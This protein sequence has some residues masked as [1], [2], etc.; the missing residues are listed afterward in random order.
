MD[1]KTQKIGRFRR[2]MLGIMGQPLSKML[3]ARTLRKKIDRSPA[4]FPADLS[5]SSDILFILPQDRVEMVFLLESLFAILGRY[6]NSNVTFLCPATHAPY[7]SGRK[8]VQVI[9]Y[10]PAE[11]QIYGAEFNRLAGELSNRAFDICVLFEKEY[12]LAHLYFVGLSRAHLRIGWDSGN[13]YP[14]LNVRLV[15]TVRKGVTVWERNLEIAKILDANADTT[16]RWGV[17]QTTADEVMQLL[18]EYKLKKDLPLICIDLASLER[19]CGGAWC[20]ELLNAL[21]GSGMRQFYIFG[22]PEEEHQSFKE[23]PF[24]VLPSMSIP[25]TAALIASTEVV[26]TGP[27][28]MLG[29]AQISMSKIV[30]ALTNEDAAAYCKKSANIMPVTFTG[31]PDNKAIKAVVQNVRTLLAA[32]PEKHNE[33]TAEEAE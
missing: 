21:K 3:I 20:G 7:V 25:R 18:G 4:A 11:F 31:E 1:K 2:T 12:T 27:G 23:T 29:L 13:A 14:F 24:P 17:Q 9:K 26:I 16:V 8:R 10:N 6:K 22:G 32:K 30:P 5:R 15:P 28:A 33:Q 19:T